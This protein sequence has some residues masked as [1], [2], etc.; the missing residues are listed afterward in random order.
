MNPFFAYS[1]SFILVA[2]TSLI[3]QYFTSQ[4]TKTK[5]FYCVSPKESPPSFVF[6]IVWSLLYFCIFIAFA[7]SLQSNNSFLI[8]LILINLLLNVLWCYF[9][10]F[11]KNILFALYSILFL[12]ISSIAIIFTSNKNNLPFV[13]SLFI[14]YT[15]WLLFALF[16]NVKSLQKQKKCKLL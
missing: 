8:I 15:I 5:W 16:L 12:I 13:A 2:L 6:P 4:N 3:G 14:P 11:K 9:Y 7:T 1:I 10:F